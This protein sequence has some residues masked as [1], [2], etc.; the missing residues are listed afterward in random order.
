MN[1]SAADPLP[2]LGA[3]LLGGSGPPGL[4]DLT[5]KED[6]LTPKEEPADPSKIPSSQ[7]DINA[8]IGTIGGPGLPDNPPPTSAPPTSSALPNQSSI[9]PAPANPAEIMNHFQPGPNQEQTPGVPGPPQS[10]ITPPVQSDPQPTQ[11]QPEAMNVEPSQNLES[12][13]TK[14][15]G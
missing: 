14:E 1:V 8:L 3:N 12:M 7:V 13:E 9:P 2:N 5:V 11:N 10:E 15:E 6:G 4:P